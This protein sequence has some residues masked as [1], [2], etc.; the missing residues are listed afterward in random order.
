MKKDYKFDG[1][2]FIELSECF[3]IPEAT[4]E[5]FKDY[6]E[7]SA[8]DVTR[9]RDFILKHAVIFQMEDPENVPEES[10]DVA[11]K[12]REFLK[13]LIVDAKKW[14]YCAPLWVGLSKI[15]HDGSFLEFYAKLVNCMWN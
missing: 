9:L 15:K 10:K 7:R 13:E 6:F 5:E 4:E 3:E 8:E 14:H 2:D 11:V 1:F 12:C